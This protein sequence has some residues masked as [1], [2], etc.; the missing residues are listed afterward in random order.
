MGVLHAKV[1]GAWVPLSV[2]SGGPPGP[3]GATG[4]AGPTGPQGPP[5]AGGATSAYVHH[6]GPVAASWIV[7]H[8]L[9]YFPN[10]TVIDSG[11]ATCEGDV[12][13]I[14]VTTLTI[15]FSA[16]FSGTAYLS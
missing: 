3:T 8:N 4:P 15:Q 2:G 5:G 7:V 10:V 12:G 1:S 13:H 16:G 9:G 6:Q 11:G 14:D